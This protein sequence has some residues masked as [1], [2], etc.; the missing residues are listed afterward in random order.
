MGL[1][2]DTSDRVMSASNAMVNDPAMAFE[3]FNALNEM[4]VTD[5]NVMTKGWWLGFDVDRATDIKRDAIKGV[6]QTFNKVQ[7]KTI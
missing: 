5:P 4:F 2:R 7:Y 6:L 3:S 1:K